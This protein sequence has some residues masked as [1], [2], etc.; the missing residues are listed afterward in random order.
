M[1]Y[2]CQYPTCW[3]KDQWTKCTT[4]NTWLFDI[5]GKLGCSTCR[6]VQSLRP[7]HSSAGMRVQLATQ[8]A[9]PAAFSRMVTS[10]FYVDDN[11][12]DDE[13][14]EIVSNFRRRD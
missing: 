12:N 10:V 1:G 14:D 4:D 8:W 6:T 5:E 7:N 9:T 11:E 13:N 3:T 2:F